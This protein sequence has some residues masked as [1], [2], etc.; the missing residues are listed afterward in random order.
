MPYKVMSTMAK[1]RVKRG[2][3]IIK[4]GEFAVW[5]KV[6]QVSPYWGKNIWADSVSVPVGWGWSEQQ[7]EP[8]LLSEIELKSSDKRK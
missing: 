2:R 1:Y 7:R 3:S 5:G 8:L 4:D 6:A